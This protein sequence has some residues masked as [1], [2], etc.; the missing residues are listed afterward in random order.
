[1]KTSLKLARALLPFLLL[2]FLTFGTGAQ[3]QTTL[4]DTNTWLPSASDTAASATPGSI[5]NSLTDTAGNRFA[6]STHRIRQINP[7]VSNAFATYQ[8]LYPLTGADSCQDE[9]VIVTS[10]PGNE[11]QMTAILRAQGG[12]TLYAVEQNAGNGHIFIKKS[13]AGVATTLFDDTLGAF[14]T[15]T[16]NFTLVVTAVGINPTTFTEVFT[17]TTTSTVL[18]SF[19]HT[20]ATAALQNP[21]GMG[22]ACEDSNDSY[23]S[24]IQTFNLASAAPVAATGYSLTL[25]AASGAISSPVT[26]TYAL[27]GGTTSPGTTITPAQSGVSGSF[28][29][30]TVS[31]S[32]ATPSASITFTPTSAGTA[33]FTAANTSD[34]ASLTSTA[35]QSPAS[36]TY[37]VAAAAATILVTN[38]NWKFSPNWRNVSGEMITD[39]PGASFKFNFSGT[40]AVLNMDT[41]SLTTATTEQ[42]L[43]SIDGK[44]WTQLNVPS[45]NQY[46]LATGLAAGTH[47]LHFVVQQNPDGQLWTVTAGAY[48]VTGLT[49]D[50]GGTLSAP[51]GEA[52]L[53]PNLLYVY[54]DSLGNG[55]Y[56]RGFPELPTEAYPAAV[57]AAFN[58]ELCQM[59]RGGQGFTI[60]A[61]S[62]FP[63]LFTPGNDASS[64]WNKLSSSA[65]LLTT[66]KFTQ[67]PSQVLIV[68]GTND[69]VHGGSLTAMTT[70]IT[71][72]LPALRAACLSTTPIF[73]CSLPSGDA[74][75]NAALT[76]GFNAYQSSTP[77]AKCYLLTIAAVPGLQNISAST[78]S[79]DGLHPNSRGQV[80]LSGEIVQ[81]MQ[82]AVGTTTNITTP[83]RRIQ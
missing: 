60:T 79:A 61:S 54:G 38:S 75:S 10:D 4:R 70:S 47:T 20:D 19:T 11:T 64:T 58:S 26:L 30:A 14:P 35:A 16:H 50:A 12:N 40:S 33:T 17:D 81:A 67:M 36:R 69:W 55:F 80:I 68:Q 74:A 24:R 56:M 34:G 63:P 23:Y 13:I 44:P 49:L 6:V 22:T 28:S 42:A 57:A 2:L 45:S 32:T 73:L 77:D 51:T 59:T 9:K 43:V 5:G 82:A 53:A 8:L 71:G 48:A 29:A 25:S 39:C 46:T 7:F 15:A 37:T 27:T 41:S 66:G 1:M 83:K 78:L 3:A 65:S 18:G 52:A 72:F 21:G 31:L 62:G 76:S